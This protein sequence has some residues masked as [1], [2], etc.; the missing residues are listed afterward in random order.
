MAEK[1]LAASVSSVSL[2]GLVALFISQPASALSVIPGASG[3]GLDT[4]AGRGGTVYKVTNLNASGTGS[5]TA[6]VNASGPRVCVFEVSG[7]ISINGQLDIINPNI[8]IAGQTAPSPGI[9]LRNTQVVIYTS[10]VLIQHIH[11][12]AGDAVNGPNPEDRDNLTIFGL[13][14]NPARNIVIDHNSFS[15]SIDEMVSAWGNWD[16]VTFSNNIFAEPLHESLHPKGAHGYGPLLSGPN[17]GSVSVIGNLFAHAAYR[18]PASTARNFVYANN[19]V[20]NRV[21]ADVSIHDYLNVPIN[22]SFVGNSFIR[23]PSFNWNSSPILIDSALTSGSKIYVSD[24]YAT[25]R[26][27]ATQTSL[28]GASS[29]ASVSG[30]LVSTLPAWPTGLVALSTANNVAY[31]SVLANAGAR[32]TDRDT[33]DTRIVNSVKNRTGQI[34][35]CVAADGSTRCSKNAG[36]WPT[37]AANTRALTLPADPN[38]VR[39]DGYTNLEAWLHTYS[40]QV[41]N[42]TGNS[43][44]TVEPMPPVQVIVQ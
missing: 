7:T 33:V 39:S 34:V 4:P 41:E 37:M 38:A 31:N 10:N 3:Y 1:I 18:N 14:S 15:W 17:A 29:G 30:L 26:S 25:E 11:F 5:L 12:R 22:A 24:N 21:D 20:Y 23:G 43:T 40:A 27:G 9:M 19:V 36:G 32:P 8:T 6:C 35:N 2:A 28:V 16:Q 42:S 44:S 13:E